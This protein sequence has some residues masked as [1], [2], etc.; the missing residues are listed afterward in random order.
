MCV[1]LSTYSQTRGS[2]LVVNAHLLMTGEVATFVFFN[3]N[4]C[5]FGRVR[6]VRDRKDQTVYPDAITH[7]NAHRQHHNQHPGQQR[8][9]LTHP[10]M[11]LIQRG[12]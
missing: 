5:V 6:C 12:D 3:K 4:K 11:M 8:P 7:S 1:L 10:H 9:H 2:D